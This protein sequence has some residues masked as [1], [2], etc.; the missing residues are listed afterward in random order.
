M[1]AKTHA[2]GW[3]ILGIS[4]IGAGIFIYFA[5]FVFG[6]ASAIL[7]IPDAGSG[8]VAMF[9]LFALTVGL[10]LTGLAI[11]VLKVVVDRLKN[12]EDNYYSKNV[13]R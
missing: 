2:S 1:R 13:E 9:A 7:S 12:S 5:F 3:T 4:L 11:L 10:P 6:M 8:G